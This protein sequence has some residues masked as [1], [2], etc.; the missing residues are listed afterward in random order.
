MQSIRKLSPAIALVA[1]SI[2]VGVVSVR[3]SPETPQLGTATLTSLLSSII[4]N[5]NTVGDDTFSTMDPSAM[6]PPPTQHD[7]PFAGSSTD[8]GTCGNDWAN[9]VFTRF[10]SI[11]SMNGA[12]VVVEQFKNGTFTTPAS[13]SPS[14]NPSPGACDNGQTYDG[15]VVNNG[16]TG[17]FHGYFIIPIPS[18]ITETNNSPH[19]D[20]TTGAD[21]DC[22]TTTFIDTHFSGCAYPAVC[23]VTTFFFHYSGGLG[24]GLI[25]NSWIDSSPDR[26]GEI[27]D[28]RST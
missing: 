19:C 1:L 20:A 16:V 5:V 25:A 27:G 23:S 15:G 6:S 28:I 9:D 7:G 10:F 11:F 2:A 14:L 26:A 18:G 17:S 4:N 24:Q 3:A 13:D 21:S 12:I 8:S 22:N